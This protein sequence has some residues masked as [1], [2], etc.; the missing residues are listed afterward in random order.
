M[1]YRMMMMKCMMM[2]YEQPAYLLVTQPTLQQLC[3][4]LAS[5]K[6]ELQLQLQLYFQYQLCNS[7]PTPTPTLHKSSIIKPNH[8]LNSLLLSPNALNMYKHPQELQISGP[9]AHRTVPSLRFIPCLDWKFCI[10]YR[11]IEI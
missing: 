10:Q 6:P 7:A 8:P 1:I 3:S 11:T 5:S 2:I 4:T 9:L